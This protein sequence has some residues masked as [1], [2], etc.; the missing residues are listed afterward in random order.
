MSLSALKLHSSEPADNKTVTSVAEPEQVSA[1][2]AA[3]IA[4][5]SESSWWRLH[6]SGQVPAPNKLGGRTLWVLGGPFGLR[7]WIR[8]GCPSRQAWKALTGRK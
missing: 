2:E 7:E 8:Q 3:R 5:V 4:G 6:A 1:A